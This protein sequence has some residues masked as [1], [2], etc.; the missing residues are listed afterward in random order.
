MGYGRFS[1]RNPTGLALCAT[2]LAA[3]ATV[4][5]DPDPTPLNPTAITE[6]Q[7]IGSALADT[8]AF[9]STIL[10]YTRANMQRSESRNKVAGIDDEPVVRIERLDKKLAWSLD[11][12]TRRFAECPLRGCV[13]AVGRKTADRKSAGDDK[14]RETE[15]RLRAGNT[16]VSVEPTGRKRS[17]GGLDTEQYD[18]RWIVTFRDNAARK[19]VST[20][21][22]DAWVAPATPEWNKATAIEKDYLR[23]RDKSLGVESDRAGLLPAAALKMIGTYLAPNV[24]PSDR[25]SFLAGA[26]KVDKLK[27]EAILTTVNWSFSGEACAMNEAKDAAGDA[28][29]FTLSSEI[30]SH[31]VEPRHDSIFAPPRDYKITR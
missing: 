14:P 6:I 18:V 2:L 17:I 24:S 10:T 1:T 28:P 16:T 12:K 30:K 19:S 7:T 15:C 25:A 23:A 5:R 3:C 29:L 9:D 13:G 20:V 11:A 22:I 27:G 31:R 4:P 26:K 21:A 8:A